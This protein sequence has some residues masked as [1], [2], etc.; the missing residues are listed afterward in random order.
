[1][2]LFHFFFLVYILFAWLNGCFFDDAIAYQKSSASSDRNTSSS[3]SS[4]QIVILKDV[5]SDNSND[6]SGGTQG[7]WTTRTLNTIEGTSSLVNLSSNQF[8][9]Q[10]GSYFLKASAPAAQPQ[11]SQIRLYNVTDS[12][13]AAV[14]TLETGDFTRSFLE[15][16]FTIN[17]PKTFK[18]E[19]FTALQLQHSIH[20]HSS[21]GDVVY[22]I[23]TIQKI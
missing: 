15:S 8:T 12:T 18:I 19:H 10:A 1:M 16:Y 6:T 5:R 20:P 14:G 2:R 11:L 3:T 22:S 13:V 9:L 17:S 21:M 7:A 4:P 23:V